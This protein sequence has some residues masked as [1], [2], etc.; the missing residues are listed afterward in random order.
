MTSVVLQR[1]HL[2]ELLPWLEVW[3]PATGFCN[4]IIL[5]VVKGKSLFK[6]K[7]YYCRAECGWHSPQRRDRRHHWFS[8]AG[9]VGGGTGAV[10]GVPCLETW[11]KQRLGQVCIFVDWIKWCLSSPAEEKC[12]KF[13]LVDASLI[14]PTLIVELVKSPLIVELVKSP[15]IAELPSKLAIPLVPWWN[16]NPSIP[17]AEKYFCRSNWGSGKKCTSKLE[18]PLSPSTW[19]PFS[20]AASCWFDLQIISQ[21]LHNCPS[22]PI[23]R[24]GE[25][26]LSLSIQ[27]TG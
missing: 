24:K 7:R 13:C 12:V 18:T 1:A 19:S 23:I 20:T 22:F 8:C 9:E 25:R 15:L 21:L 11:A 16:I 10:G 17:N 2:R 4:W 6:T 26:I 5:R 27:A 3:R 14:V